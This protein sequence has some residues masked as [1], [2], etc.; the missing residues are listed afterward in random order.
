[1]QPHGLQHTRLP[2]PSP[3]PRA[4]WSSSPSNLWCHP[5]ISSSVISFSSG[6]HSLPASESFPMSQFFASGVQS[7]GVSATMSVLPVNNQD[8]FPLGLTGLISLQ[9]KGLSRVFSTTTGQ[10]HQFFSPQLSLWSNNRIHI[11]LLKQPSL[12]HTD[13]WQQSDVSAF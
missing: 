3:T 4:C 8:W 2:C 1:M 10:K 6:L 9:A 5:T 13:L 7:T 11:W 12:W